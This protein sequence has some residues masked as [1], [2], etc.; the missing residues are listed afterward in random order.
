MSVSSPSVFVAAAEVL[1]SLGLQAESKVR[2]FEGFAEKV[3]SAAALDQEEEETFGDIPDDFLVRP[4][5]L[6]GG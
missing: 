4:F 3:R 6:K 1:R 2:A 5:V